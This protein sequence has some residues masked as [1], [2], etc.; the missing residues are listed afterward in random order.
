MQEGDQYQ[1]QFN[2]DELGQVYNNNVYDLRNIQ[3]HAMTVDQWAQIP[4]NQTTYS[5]YWE[6]PICFEPEHFSNNIKAETTF[7]DSTFAVLFIINFLISIVL[8]VF[9]S[10]NFNVEMFQN[11]F[12]DDQL[13]TTQTVQYN[14]KEDNHQE[15]EVIYFN[16]LSTPLILSLVIGFGIN[17]LHFVYA[18][19]FSQFYIKFGMFVGLAFSIIS[20]IV[21]LVIGGIG[22]CIAS[23]FIVFMSI[24]WYCII[25]SRIPF[26][27]SIFNITTKLV[28][29]NPSILLICLL[30]TLINVLV[31]CG[32][33]FVCLC[34]TV[35]NLS[36]FWYVYCI[37]SY[38]WITLTISYVIYMTGAGV[39]ASWYF[40]H[41]TEYYPPSP[42]WSSFKRSITTSFGSCCF[43]GFILAAIE[44]ARVLVN[45]LVKLS[46]DRQNNTEVERDDDRAREAC[47]NIF[48]ALFSCIAL[49]ILD[50]LESFVNWLTRYA[51]I[52]CAMY[53]I[54]YKEGCKRWAELEFTRFVNVLIDGC[55]IKD[56]INYNSIVFVVVSGLISFPISLIFFKIGSIQ[57]ILIVVL[58]I[59]F[60]YVGLSFLNNPVIT[61][62]D[63][64]LVCFSESPDTLKDSNFE[65]YSILC[66]AYTNQL[67]TRL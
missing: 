8:I 26:S 16:S 1:R 37:F 48:C 43:A 55:V 10:I 12:K 11:F 17:I 31:N 20:S 41:N 59:I 29:E 33:L 53:G 32:Y 42:T 46:S 6:N 58:S 47:S 67:N 5:Q 66:R 61:M 40:L 30:E 25:R 28:L 57:N 51:L 19:F 54:P 9:L 14:I 45:L 15:S 27:A 36:P 22:Q 49:C 24:L 4:N 60:T 56:A 7:Y 2:Q 23:G 63:T 64:L 3:Y 52:Y 50:L 38:T 35:M 18:H 39:A 44:A 21:F 62:S 34:T 65:L 13:N